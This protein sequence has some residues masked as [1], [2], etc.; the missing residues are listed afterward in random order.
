MAKTSPSQHIKP[1]DLAIFICGPNIG[2]LVHVERAFFGDEVIEG[3]HF[4]KTPGHPRA[5]VVRSLGT[6]LISKF[7]DG[8]INPKHHQVAAFNEDALRPLRPGRGEDQTLQWAAKRTPKVTT[9]NT[10]GG[11]EP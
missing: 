7:V 2:K 3:A 10:L 9:A 6:P 1:G 8:E 11:L 5:W 4:C